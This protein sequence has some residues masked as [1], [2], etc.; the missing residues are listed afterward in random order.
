MSGREAGTGNAGFDAVKG[1]TLS[2][3]SKEHAHD[4]RY[5]PE[6][7]LPPVFVTDEYI[8]N[9]KAHMPELPSELINKYI[10]VYGL[11]PTMQG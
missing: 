11:P 7:D 10:T 6:P 4:Y 1:V 2:Q 3:R 9:V 8:A 5:F